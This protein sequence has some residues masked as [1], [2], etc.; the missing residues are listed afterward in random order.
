VDTVWTKSLKMT[1]FKWL[2][3]KIQN[4]EKA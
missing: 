2:R 3:L 4:K 1:Q